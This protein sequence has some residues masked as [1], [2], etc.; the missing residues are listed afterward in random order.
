MK[1][2]DDFRIRHM[3]EAVKK[4][5]AFTE[6][7]TRQSFDQEEQLS[8]SVVRLLEIIGEAA[9]GVSDELKKQSDDIP[10]KEIM[11]TRDRL[12]HGYFDVDLD[13]VWQIVATDLPPLVGQ[14]EK[15]IA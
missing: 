3:L 8:L 5:L 1:N 4:I 11:R 12:I 10:W 15:L 13:I 7:K 9:K 6:G 2:N 14:L